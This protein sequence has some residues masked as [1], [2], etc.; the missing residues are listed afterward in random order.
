M[1]IV[2]L[3]GGLG[4]QLFQYAY[5]KSLA[6]RNKCRLKLDLSMFEFDTK[7]DY[8]LMPFKIEAEL[9]SKR[10]C[11]LLK[12]QNLNFFDTIIKKIYSPKWCV[13]NE[14]YFEKTYKPIV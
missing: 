13:I 8:S 6:T 5:G 3:S 9:A 14:H 11:N 10:E 7:R 4:N 2:Q 1:V 12:G